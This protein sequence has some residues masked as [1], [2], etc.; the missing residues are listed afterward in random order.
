M[1]DD[2]T[3]AQ[4][5]TAK[6]DAIAQL[7]KLVTETD[8]TATAPT[9]TTTL[10]LPIAASGPDKWRSFICQLKY[11]V[12]VKAYTH[13]LPD[14]DEPV[15]V[16][17]TTSSQ[18]NAQWALPNPIQKHKAGDIVKIDVEV[19]E[20]SNLDEKDASIEIT[21]T[22]FDDS[23]SAIRDLLDAMGKDFSSTIQA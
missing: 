19:G 9:I 11:Y 7:Q 3:D 2:L 16:G 18:G 8:P 1:S 12:V 22:A 5:Q 6:T 14:V 13:A 21:C 17:T 10:S 15:F 23:N 20:L 4:Y